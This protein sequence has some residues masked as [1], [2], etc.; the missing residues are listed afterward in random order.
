MKIKWK[1]LTA[2]MMS[3]AMMAASLTGCGG[4]T[5]TNAK[6]NEVVE[7]T[8]Y[9]IGDTQKDL[10]TVLEKVNEY[11]AEKIGVKLKIN[12]ISWGDYNQKMQV[13]INTGD[14]WDLCFTCAWAND[15]LQN[16]QK[17]AFLQIDDYLQNEGKGMHETIDKRFW[18]AAKVDGKTYG[19]PN[20]KEIGSSP[21][22]VFTKEYVDKYNVPYQDIH[23]LED[24]EPWL[25]LIKENEPEVVPFYL[26]KDYSA[27]TYMDKIQDPVG[28]EYGDETLTVK[29]IFETEKMKSTLATM[30]KYYLAGYINKDAATTSDDKSI[31]RFVTKGDGQ[32]YAELIWGK[33]LNYEVVAT[34]IMEA[35]VT[36]ISA[37][38]SLTAINKNS[39]H[40]E[41]AV[42]LLN[43]INTD[44]YLRNL[45]NYG[46]EGV[47]YEK[48]A[49]TD[50]ELKAAEGKPYVYDVKLKLNEETKKDYSVPYWV[51]GGLFNTYVLENEPLDKWATFKEFND[52]SKEAPSFGFDFN[53][54]PVSTQVAGFRNILDEFGR[55]LYTGSVDPDEYLPQMQKKLEATGIQEVIDEMQRQIDEWKTTK[56]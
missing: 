1:K 46:I 37:R 2:L 42:E 3:A 19:V 51:Q 20:E 4:S 9:Q 54:E 47:H 21:M 14:K 36:N 28:I 26:T 7:L 30:R 29:N 43:L 34:E 33:D 50:E 24:L 8:W 31:K 35:Q 44:E 52:S 55:S 49:P 15:Y 56:K 23:T 22:W 17:G 38:G 16:V 13:I 45:L 53:L 12:N 18:D 27:P 5:Q 39:E 25:E 10:D 11:T 40:P 48:V 41:K 6:G 32:P